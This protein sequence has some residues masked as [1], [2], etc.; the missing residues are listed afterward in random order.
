MDDFLG[1]IIKKTRSIAVVGLS[2]DPNKVS[3]SVAE[4][5]RAAGYLII[6]INPMSKEIMGLPCYPSL[7]QIPD[8]LL[9]ML[10]MV[11]VFRRSEDIPPIVDEAVDLHSRLGKPEIIW[12][13]SGIVNE[14][15]AGRARRAGLAV[16]MDKCL[17][18]EHNR[19]VFS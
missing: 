12:M 4:Y 13:Q 14:E 15:A 17:R 10:D 16:V 1:R 19:T 9:Q 6:P 8:A 7:S 2:R 11:D 5:L 18:T 3:F